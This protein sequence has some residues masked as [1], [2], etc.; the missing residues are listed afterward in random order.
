VSLISDISPTAAARESPQNA[1]LIALAA[2]QGSS[3]RR[4]FAEMQS[5]APQIAPKGC[6]K[7]LEKGSSGSAR[8]TIY[9]RSVLQDPT[10]RPRRQRSW[11]E[12]RQAG[13][14]Q[15]EPMEMR[16]PTYSR[17]SGQRTQPSDDSNPK[18]HKAKAKSEDIRTIYTGQLLSQEIS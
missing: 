2:E 14:A 13:V 12:Q 7:P 10:R 8:K 4:R 17:G 11:N 3:K 6:G 18:A 1:P 15:I 9:P 16:G 5:A